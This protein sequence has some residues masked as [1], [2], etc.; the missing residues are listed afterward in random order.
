MHRPRKTD[1]ANYRCGVRSTAGADRLEQLH[2]RPHPR[3]L[4]VVVMT[5]TTIHPQRVGPTQ[6]ATPECR[7]PRWGQ[8]RPGESQ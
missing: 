6:A 1:R 5:T 4:P 7:H 8:N 3:G 2:P